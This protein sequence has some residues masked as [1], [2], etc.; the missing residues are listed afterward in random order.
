MCFEQIRH[1]GSVNT[2]PHMRL[3]A[4][5]SPWVGTGYLQRCTGMKFLHWF[6]AL[7]AFVVVTGCA[8][9]SARSS[10]EASAPTVDLSG[11][12][13]SVESTA[14]FVD[15]TSRANQVE[16]CSVS[17][18]GDL[19][20]TTCVISGRPTEFVSQMACMAD[21]PE[22]SNCQMT[23]LLDSTSRIPVGTTSKMTYKLSGSRLRVTAYPRK[24]SSLESGLP[25]KVVSVMERE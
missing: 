12:W 13:R 16:T 8:V 2:A 10:G 1:N 9:P 14:Y 21:E 15:G 4:A 6:A 19:S 25:A 23:V 20:T 17:I 7:G 18:R 24:G 5:R 22:I 3:A 11:N